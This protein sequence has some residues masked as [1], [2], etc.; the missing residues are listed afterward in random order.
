M[1]I[2]GEIYHNGTDEIPANYEKSSYYLTK[3][4]EYDWKTEETLNRLNDIVTK[5]NN[6]DQKKNAS[7]LKNMINKTM[8]TQ[9]KNPDLYFERIYN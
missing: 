4:L 5:L 1:E 2:L 9:R 8:K 3:L 7:F 6:E